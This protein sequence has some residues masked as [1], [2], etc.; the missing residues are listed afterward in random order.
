LRGQQPAAGCLNLD[1]V[2]PRAAGVD[3]RHDSTKTEG[4]V[5]ASYDMS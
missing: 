1:V 3:R 5:R 4:A 2:V